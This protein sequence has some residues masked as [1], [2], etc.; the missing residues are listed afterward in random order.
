MAPVA[1]N[2]GSSKRAGSALQPATATA[3][4]AGS[5]TRGC[6]LR[7]KYPKREHLAAMP[8]APHARNT[9]PAELT[10]FG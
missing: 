2:R 3:I 6:D 7:G 5:N 4:N 1:S 8:I 10:T 9:I